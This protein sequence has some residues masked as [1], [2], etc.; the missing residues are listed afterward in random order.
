MPQ[1]PKSNSKNGPQ[2]SE[3]PAVSETAADD[4]EE[5]IGPGY[6]PKEYRWPPGTSGNPK[7]AKPKPRSILLDFK[8]LFERALSKKVP[9]TKDERKR[10]LTKFEFGMEQ[11]ANQFAKGDR[12][13]RRDVFALA[14]KL[15]IDLMAEQKKTLDNAVASNHQAILDAYVDR[16]YDKV[17]QREAEMAPSELLDDDVDDRNGS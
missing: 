11:L 1:N 2:N 15:G 10:A 5:E 8:P 7:G 3:D 13:A 6:P 4:T 12:Y 16:Q 14:D 9:I 17:V